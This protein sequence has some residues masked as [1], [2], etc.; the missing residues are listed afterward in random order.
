[1]NYP[2]YKKALR[3]GLISGFVCTALWFANCYFISKLPAVSEVSL[4]LAFQPW[5]RHWLAG[6]VIFIAVSIVV[7]L[8]AI[9]RPNF[10]KK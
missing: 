8:I 4:S 7:G 1:M 10:P 9:L 2:N 6:I 5:W 3:W